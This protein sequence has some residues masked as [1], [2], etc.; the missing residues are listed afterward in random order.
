M[1]SGI[2]L[3]QLTYKKI[4]T[5]KRLI[6]DKEWELAAYLMGYILE[7]ALKAASCKALK[8]SGYPP[9]RNKGGKV[10]GFKTHEFEQLLIVSGLNDLW[11]KVSTDPSYDNWST[12]TAMYPGN[13]TEMRYEIISKFDEI[14]TKDL[15]KKLYDNTDS[16]I[17]TIKK[18]KRW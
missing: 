5:V 18:K 11:G 3:R 13:W 16:I 10:D 7:Y 6:K 2:D 15:A 8:L 9:V 4:K 14:T 12:F 1:T 17:E